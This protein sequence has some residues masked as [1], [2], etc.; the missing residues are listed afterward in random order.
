M[1]VYLGRPGALQAVPGRGLK[2]A[3]SRLRVSGA[4]TTI[5]GGRTRDYIGT[6]V[7][8]SWT[9]SWS[10]LDRAL[11]GFVEALYAGLS[12]PGPFVL[13]DS[14]R[15][16]LLTTNQSGATSVTNGTDGFSAPGA[17]ELLTSSSTVFERGPRSLAWSLPAA[18]AGGVLTLTAPNTDWPGIPC[19]PG[20]TYRLQGRVRGAGTDPIITV[21]AQLRWLDAAGAQVQLDAGAGVATS[22]GAWADCVIGATTCPAGAVYLAPR[23]AV[24]SATVGVG[25]GTVH[26]DR[27]Q[28]AMPDAFDDGTVW[29]PGLGVPRVSLPQLDDAPWHTQLHRVG[30]LLEEVS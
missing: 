3:P 26:V 15:T 9:L 2:V 18:P 13:L 11:L 22:A 16:N 12:G 19:V 28:L 1:T 4:A 29:R 23:L 20:R 10:A 27:L 8:G 21:A 25:G 7:L 6:T 17:G 24:T 14:G 5:G 30:L